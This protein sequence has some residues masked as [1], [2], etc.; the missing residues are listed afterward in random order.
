MRDFSEKVVEKTK[1]QVLSSEFYSENRAVFAIRWKNLV[2]P[3]KPCVT[4]K[5]D[6]SPLRVG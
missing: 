1:T 2:E 5:H 6:A 3:D 4:M